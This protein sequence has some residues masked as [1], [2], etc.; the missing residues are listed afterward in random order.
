MGLPEGFDDRL[1]A[2]LAMIERVS[3]RIGASRRL[4]AASDHQLAR[5]AHRLTG[6]GQVQ[7]GSKRVSEQEP[8]IRPQH[9]DPEAHRQEAE[10]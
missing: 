10:A 2:V 7:D 9:N 8:E 6:H 5:S 1:A 4:L 3:G